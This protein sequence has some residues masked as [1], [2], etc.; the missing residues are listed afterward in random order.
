MILLGEKENINWRGKCK[1]QNILFQKFRKYLTIL[2]RRISGS[3]FIFPESALPYRTVPF[4][5]G[6]RNP[7]PVI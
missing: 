2:S 4:G 7:E 5:R 3:G 6:I 1:L